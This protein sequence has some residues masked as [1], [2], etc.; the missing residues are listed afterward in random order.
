[1]EKEKGKKKRRCVFT[2]SIGGY[3]MKE[4]GLCRGR[5]ESVKTEKG[6]RRRKASS[7][8]ASLQGR[9]KY[10]GRGE[11]A[12]SREKKK[13]GERRSTIHFLNGRENI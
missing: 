2:S 6:E 1:L 9:E 7:P 13:G 3:R 5:E 8:T 4:N 12:S 10:L 11:D